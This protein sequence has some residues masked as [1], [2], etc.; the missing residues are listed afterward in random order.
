VVKE[1]LPLTPC[2]RNLLDAR[3]CLRSA[4]ELCALVAFVLEAFVLEVFVPE[5]FVPRSLLLALLDMELLAPCALLKWLLLLVFPELLVRFVPL[6][7][8]DSCVLLA[9][10]DRFACLELLEPCALLEE[11]KETCAVKCSLLV[12]V[13]LLAQETLKVSMKLVLFL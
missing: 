9:P 5:A 12:L 11:L 2:C 3:F 13:L 6:A 8:P 4:L 7:H 10:L 1:L